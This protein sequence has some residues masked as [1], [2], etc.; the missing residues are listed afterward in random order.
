MNIDDVLNLSKLRREP[1]WM[2]KWRINAFY[3]LMFINAP[4]WSDAQSSE[5]D[6]SV[7]A[8]G[9]DYDELEK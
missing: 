9:K 8:S 4:K 3:C 2:V 6:V 1:N 5:V 7:N